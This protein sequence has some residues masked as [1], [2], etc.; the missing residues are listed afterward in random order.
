MCGLCEK[1]E[2]IKYE[3]ATWKALGHKKVPA[4]LGYLGT[5]LPI[6]HL[7]S[8]HAFSEIECDGEVAPG[9]LVLKQT[10]RALLQLLYN[11]P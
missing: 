4:N 6:K 9:F 10:Q 2:V 8:I 11:R 1:I 7:A 3:V 5:Y